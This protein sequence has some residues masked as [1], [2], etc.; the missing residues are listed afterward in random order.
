MGGGCVAYID[1]KSEDKYKAV[2]AVM[3][4]QQIEIDA[5]RETDTLMMA[6]PKWLN[7]IEARNKAI[8][9]LKK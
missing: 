7:L 9:E 2:L 3:E 8:R 6:D 1:W 4:R 5:L